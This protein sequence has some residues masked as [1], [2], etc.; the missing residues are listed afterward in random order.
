MKKSS[1]PSEASK[2]QQCT[3]SSLYFSWVTFA[4]GYPVGLAFL[5]YE[6]NWPVFAAWLILLPCAKWAYLRYFPQISK[7]RGYGSIY[8]TL[9]ASVEKARA[10]VTFYSLLGC[11]FCPIVAQRL[12]ALQKEMDFA[13]TKVDLT[14]R[15]QLAASKGIKSVP[16]VETGKGRLVGNATTEQL[17]QLIAGAQ[18]SV[19]AHAG[20]RA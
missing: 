3:V 12:D 14:L 4:I 6:G 20:Y 19:P 1:Q 2:K 8:D 5:G 18:A 11:P 9:P 16:V 17:A 10:E 7:L 15:P 13:L